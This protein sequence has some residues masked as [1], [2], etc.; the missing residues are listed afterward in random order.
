MKPIIHTANLWHKILPIKG[1]FWGFHQ[2]IVPLNPHIFHLLYHIWWVD[3]IRSDSC[4]MNPWPKFLKCQLSVASS[5]PPL[6]MLSFVGEGHLVKRSVF[7]LNQLSKLQTVFL[8]LK[9]F[10]RSGTP[11]LVQMNKHYLNG[12]VQESGPADQE[13]HI[14]VSRFED[15]PDSTPYLRLRQHRGGSHLSF[16]PTILPGWSAP[17][18]S[19]WIRG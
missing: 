12:I 5:Q 14:V 10:W 17:Q 6:S 3:D 11:A 7:F 16:E 18:N 15:Y 19:L 9:K 4:L 2:C 1:A 8:A 13:N